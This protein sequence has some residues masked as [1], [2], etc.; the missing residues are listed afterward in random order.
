[1]PH[2]THVNNL[3][4]MFFMLPTIHSSD[5]CFL[6]LPL[7]T[8]SIDFVWFQGN[9]HVQSIFMVDINTTNRVLCH[10]LFP[11]FQGHNMTLY[12]ICSPKY[13]KYLC[14]TFIFI[15]LISA[16]WQRR[17]I[18]WCYPVFHMEKYRNT[19]ITSTETPWIHDVLYYFSCH[20]V[21]RNHE[22]LEWDVACSIKD[23]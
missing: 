8:I 23:D 1:M 15:A 5:L 2:I 3:T 20:Y 13:K 7:F 4:E 17:T 10:I 12:S 6:S 18:K 16:Y 14:E 19:P 22:M 9:L 11:F 21:R